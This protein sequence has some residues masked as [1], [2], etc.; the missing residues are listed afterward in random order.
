M[1]SDS[2]SLKFKGQDLVWKLYFFSPEGHQE[3][4]K[5]HITCHKSQNTLTY[6]HTMLVTACHV[7]QL[8]CASRAASCDVRNFSTPFFET[9][10]AVTRWPKL[11]CLLVILISPAELL[12][13][14]VMHWSQIWC[15]WHPFSAPEMHILC[16]DQSTVAQQAEATVA[17]CSRTSVHVSAFPD[18]FPHYAWT[19]A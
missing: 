2:Y 4:W 7:I 6:K 9:R 1:C 14:S 11:W 3:L 18:R 16:Q 13:I 19:V 8:F 17:E 15:I 12:C 10:P 5:S